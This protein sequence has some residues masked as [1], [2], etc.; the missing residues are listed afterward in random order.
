MNYSNHNLRTDLQEWKN[1][2]YRATYAQFGN[3]LKYLLNNLDSNS[4]IKGLIQ[5]A[6]NKDTF[7]KEDLDE[8]TENMRSGSDIEFESEIQQTAYCYQFLKYIIKEA[9]HY[10]LHSLTIFY[11][12]DFNDRKTKI[13][14]DYISPIV[15]YLHDKLD[16]SNSTIYLLE[17][18]KRRT[19]WFTRKEIFEK[20][21]TAN[22][23]YEQI[24]EDDL[25][26]FLFDQGIEYPFSTPTSASGRADIIGEIETDDPLVIEIKIFDRDKGYG[27]ERIKDGFNQ[28]VKYANDYN[29]DVGYLVIYN[30]DKAEL[31]FNFV[32]NSNIFPPSIQFN[33]KVFY[34]VVINSAINLTASK[35]GTIEEIEITEKELTK[36]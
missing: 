23:G 24:L 35:S 5:E 31:N 6:I 8:I 3:Q 32:E 10:N 26:L 14:E 4:Q 21:K 29:K 28:I 11:G 7:S 30:M 12:K 34:F 27:K 16:K 22:K 20:Y 25:R 36:K 15:Y 18:Y 13:V 9:K 19:E 2:L 33:N 1:R 17:K